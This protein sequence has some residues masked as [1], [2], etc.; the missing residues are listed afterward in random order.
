MGWVFVLNL[1]L[2][3][4]VF[5]AAGDWE[6]VISTTQ[7]MQS[8]RFFNIVSLDTRFHD[9]PRAFYYR[10]IAYEETGKPELA[11]ENYEALLELW[12]DADEEIPER[13]DTI[14]RLAALKQGS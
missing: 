2:K 14:K 5:S 12:K 9:Y 11:I 1:E 6:K 4:R 8:S 3:A 7:E 13:R 10:G